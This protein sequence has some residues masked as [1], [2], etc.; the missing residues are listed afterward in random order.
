MENAA[1]SVACHQCNN[2]N[3]ISEDKLLAEDA[4]I[5]LKFLRSAIFY[6]LTD[7]ENWNGHLG[8]VSSILEFTPEE[9][10]AIERV[11]RHYL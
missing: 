10:L 11:G 8:A 1:N 4:A 9:R 3:I 2:R 5:T 6:L 7:G